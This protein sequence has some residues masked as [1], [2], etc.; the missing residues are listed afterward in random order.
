[1]ILDR[2]LGMVRDDLQ[3]PELVSAPLDWGVG[4]DKADLRMDYRGSPGDVGFKLR[5]VVKYPLTEILAAIG[6]RHM[7][8]ER[9]DLDDPDRRGYRYFVPAGKMPLGLHRAAHNGD[10]G[11]QEYLVH[12]YRVVPAG[13][14]WRV[15]AVDLGETRDWG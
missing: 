2:L 15:G 8:P 14:S 10:F 6:L 5:G 13:Y 4:T 11:G 12:A 7:R 1:V 3:Q 9:F